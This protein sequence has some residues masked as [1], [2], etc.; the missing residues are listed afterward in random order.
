MINVGRKNIQQT[1]EVK[2]QL[3]IYIYI[4]IKLRHKSEGRGFDS[5]WCYWNFS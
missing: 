1:L 5:R 3:Y 2:T 4:Y